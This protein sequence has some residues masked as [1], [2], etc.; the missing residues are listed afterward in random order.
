VLTVVVDDGATWNA[1]HADRERAA[2][3]A[4][5]EK[6]IG[7]RERKLLQVLVCELTLAG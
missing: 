6:R 2:A 7:G 3:M 1:P 5:R 4:V